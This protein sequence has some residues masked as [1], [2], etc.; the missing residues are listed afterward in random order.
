MPPF[1]TLFIGGELL[2][3][4]CCGWCMTV[5]GSEHYEPTTQGAM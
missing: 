2:G 1:M 5:W 4:F 3:H